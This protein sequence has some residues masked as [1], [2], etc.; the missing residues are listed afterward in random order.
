[1]MDRRAFVTGVLAAVAVARPAQAQPSG[2]P[3]RIGRLSPVSA[4]AEAAFMEAFRNGLRELGWVEGQSFVIESRFA[5][6]RVE[7][8]PAL[9]AELVRQEVE[10]FLT[11]SNPAALAAKQAT[12]AIP[13]VMVTTADP[14]GAGIVTSLARPGGNVTG[15]TALGAV[16]NAKRLEA[17]K[18]AVPGLTRV[19]V[20]ANP[21]SP[22]YI[23]PLLKEKEALAR[24]LTLRL[25]VHEVTEADGLARAFAAMAA[26]RTG[27]LMVL[28]DVLFLTHRATIVEL[29]ARYRIPALYGERGF[30]DA[31]GLMFYGANLVDLYRRAAVYVDR[32]LK[33][34]RPA[35]LPVEQPT[36]FELVINAK[37]ARALGLAIPHS[38]VLRADQVVEP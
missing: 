24:G 9:A 11:G 21:R 23:G 31:G 15:V 7:R 19:A 30:V 14:I 22:D 28:T 27:A 18:E 29:A 4:R 1:M 10:V 34:A 36:R 33:G 25:S 12:S 16:L 32:I 17:L 8:L 13:I 3:A 5:E 20:L 2:R 37:T 6:G 26:E 38:L 35:D